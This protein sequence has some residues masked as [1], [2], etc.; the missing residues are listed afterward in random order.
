MY[1]SITGQG[2]AEISNIRPKEVT[3][4]TTHKL[5]NY[6]N[7]NTSTPHFQKQTGVQFTKNSLN[8]I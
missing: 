1:L 5:I 8:V 4:M 6:K 7:L 2:K 3:D